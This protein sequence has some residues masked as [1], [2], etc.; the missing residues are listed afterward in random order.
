MIRSV[1][2][3]RSPLVVSAVAVVLATVQSVSASPVDAAS[4]QLAGVGVF[5]AAP[6]VTCPKALPGY[7]EFDSYDPIALTGSLRGCWYTAIDPESVQ[8][9]PSGVYHEAGREVFWGSVD[10]GP[11]GT[12]TTTYE[13]EA[14]FA[15]DGAEL[16]GRCQHPIAAGSGTGGFTG[17]NGRLDFK[18]IVTDTPPS[19]VYRGHISLP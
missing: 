13:F 16:K 5:N 8:T 1:A 3:R 11:I 12:F 7:E 19:Y 2:H 15:A 10:G 4:N 17:V 6:G 9:T 14:K 18:D